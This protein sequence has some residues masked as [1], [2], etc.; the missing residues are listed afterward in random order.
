MAGGYNP[1]ATILLFNRMT[2][3]NTEYTLRWNWTLRTKCIV[4]PRISLNLICAGEFRAILI[5]FSF[6][7]PLLVSTAAAAD[8]PVDVTTGLQIE[9]PTATPGSV[10]GQSVLSFRIKNENTQS[11]HLVSVATDVA[12]S[13]RLVATLGNGEF[14]VLE[15]IGIPGAETL[16]LTTSHLHYKISPLERAL[17]PGEQFPVTFKFVEGLI[18]VVFHVHKAGS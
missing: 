13:A 12:K 6:L 8:T 9:M 5:A 17:I 3:V 18:T 7:I 2:I 10:G 14:T 16:D 11:L 1:P 15:S 4:S